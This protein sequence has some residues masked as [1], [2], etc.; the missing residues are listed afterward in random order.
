MK[1]DEGGTVGKALAL[2]DVVAA[3]GRPVRFTEVMA[4]SDHPKATL[5]R[6]LQ[7]LTGQGML[8]YDPD[9]QRYSLGGRLVRLAHAAWRQ[10]SLGPI[11]RPFLDRLSAEAGMTVHLAQLDAGQ[12]LYVDK[13]AATNPIEM[14]SDAGRVGPAYCTGVGK[15]MLAHLGAVEL[16]RALARQSFHRHTANTLTTR[17]ALVAELAAI[18]GRGYGFDDEE[19]ESAIICVAAPIR[20]PGGRLMGGLSITTSTERA[21]LSQ[22]AGYAPLLTETAG[23]IAAAAEAWRFPEEVAAE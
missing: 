3:F 9:R 7:T 14:F 19:H 12:V 20:P 15:V 22:L 6:L 4:V 16:E 21:N 18:R 2:L 10:A 11:A 1:A 5:Y 8:D 23:E 17:A 13:R